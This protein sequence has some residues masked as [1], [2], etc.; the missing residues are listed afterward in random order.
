M[1]PAPFTYHA[2]ATK[3]EVLGLLAELD[4]ARV[5]AGGQSLMPMMNLRLA[6]PAHLIDLNG[7]AELDGIR[8]EGDVLVVETMTRQRAAERSALVA[9]ACPLLHAALE[10][11]GFQ[12]TRNRGTV[13]GSI[14]HMDPTAE[15]P[16]AAS[17]LDAT[18]VV[19]SRAGARRFPF[20]ELSEGYLAT[21]IATDEMLVRVEFPLWPAGHGA[22]FEEVTRRGE[23]FSVVAVAAM[24]L[25]DGAGAFARVAIAVGGIAA[26][27]VRLADV[28]SAL[29][30]HAP[31]EAAFAMAGAAAAAQEIDEAPFAPVA[32]KRQLADVLTR[33][34]LRRAVAN[35]TPAGSPGHV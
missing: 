30:G 5:L 2:P 9:Q 32:Y 4:D 21:Q 29:L 15:L 11:V 8:L 23:S 13:G 16:V 28:E 22:A 26:A 19:E 33:R 27:P 35:A 14:A 31:D 34:A 25:L 12:Q 20:A 3:A 10:H 6:A 18:L 1:K 7:V 24:V 17:A